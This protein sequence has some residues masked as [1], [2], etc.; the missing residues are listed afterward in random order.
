QRIVDQNLKIKHLVGIAFYKEPIELM[1][2][3]LDSLANQPNARQKISVF[4]GMEQG[5]PDKDEKAK[6]LI[7]VYSKRFERFMVTVHPK[8]L[9]GEIP[10]KCSNFNYGSRV[11]VTQLRADK[12]YGLDKHTELLVTTGDCDT[13]FGERYFDALEEDYL[14]LDPKQRHRTVW[15]SPLFYCINL[16][17]SPFFVRSVGLIR[18]FFMM[19]YLIPWNINTMS[20]F[21]LSLKLFEDGEYVHPG[22]QMDDI[23]ALI[24]W[25]CAVGQ[26]CDIRAIPV[27]TLSGPTSGKNYLDELYE[28]ARQIRRWTIGAG[29]VFHYFVIKSR[30][31]PASVA[32]VWGARYIFYYGF[33]LCIASL[34]GITAPILT[35]IMLSVMDRPIK[36][37]LIPSKSAFNWILLSMLGLQYVWFLSVFVV[38]KAA[39]SVFPDKRKDNTGFLRNVFHWLMTWPTLTAYCCVELAAFLELTVR[40]K[41]VCSHSASKKDGLVKP[42][43]AAGAVHPVPEKVADRVEIV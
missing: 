25:T 2:D 4:A 19:G 27:A 30:Q 42:N 3:T 33:Q 23:I 13:I 34:Y 35:L 5:T 32:I 20:V 17:Q 40:G 43:G 16:D 8:G 14:K 18:A 31:L 38:N 37:V 9:P 29:E 22:Y 39:E 12:E 36:G 21:S 24:R 26:R 1:I 41:D 15:Q 6:K 7:S 28:W 11:S 10:G